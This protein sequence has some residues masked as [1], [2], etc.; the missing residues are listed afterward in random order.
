MRH[1]A[2]QIVMAGDG[3]LLVAGLTYD[4]SMHTNMVLLKIDAETGD[5]LWMESYGT[6]FTN[7]SM[8]ETIRTSDFGY[9][10]AGRSSYTSSQ[11]PRVY[12]MKLNSSE[13][14]ADLFL[15]K[16][17]LALSIDTDTPTKDVID[18]T[19]AKINI[20]GICVKID[21]LI[22]PSVGDLELSL[23]HDGT[24][25]T[26][27][28]QPFHSGEN[29]LQTALIDAAETP[30]EHGYAPYSGWFQPEEPLMPFLL[31]A[32]TGE[33][34]LTVT[35]HGTGGLKATSGILEGWS[36]NLLTESG[37]GTDISPQETLMN[38]GLE[39]IRP[40]PIGQEAFIAFQIAAPGPVKLRIFNQLGQLVGEPVNEDLPEGQ[41]ERMWQPGSLA[42]GTYFF[43]LESGGMI[44]VRKGVLAR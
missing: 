2:Q 17:D 13:G 14:Q 28:D 24:T 21:S 26:L 6:D 5:S 36:L 34:T 8:R 7:S 15:A 22:H 33:W 18:V 9:L 31:H 35:D 43:H 12:V 41:H 10:V 42:P 20:Y 39:Q 3:D 37:G 44:S 4:A 16:E 27:V 32:P 40:N 30:V 1:Y 38:F 29:F 23:E 19:A 25:V 11:D